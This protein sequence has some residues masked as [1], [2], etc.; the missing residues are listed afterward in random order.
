MAFQ[1]DELLAHVEQHSGE[2]LYYAVSAYGKPLRAKDDELGLC[3]VVYADADGFHPDGFRV[4]PSISVESSP[5]HWHCYW[6]LDRV[7]GQVECARVSMKLPKAHGIDASSGIQTKLLRVPGSVNTKY[8]DTHVVTAYTDYDSGDIKRY[9]LAELDAAYTDV[10]SPMD[11]AVPDVAAPSE[12]PA[13]FDVLDKVPADDRIEWLLAWDKRTADD[14]DKRSEHRWELIRRLMELS[15]LTPEEITS[16]VWDAPVSEHYREQGRGIEH[17]WKF[18]I[19]PALAKQAPTELE[20]LPQSTVDDV[21]FLT[22]DEL[23]AVMSE[24]GFVDHW[25]DLAARALHPNTPLQYLRINAY[26][27]LSACLGNRV[28]ITPPDSG[29]E[30]PY[31]NIWVLNLGPSTTGKSSA[32]RYMKRYISA[33]SKKVGYDIHAGS[34]ATAEGLIKALKAYDKRSAML[35]TDEVSGKFRSWSASTGLAHAREAE[36]EIYD[37]QLPKNLRA[38]DGAGNTDDVY[39]SFVNYMMGVPK[40]VLDP[41]YFDSGYI[42]RSIV[43]LADRQPFDSNRR[44]S[45]QQPDS[46]TAGDFDP[47]P[48]IWAERLMESTRKMVRHSNGA[49]RAIMRFDD[50]AWARFIEF[51][52]Q[53]GEFAESQEEPSIF[54]T[55]ADR[56]VVTMQKL[57]ALTAYERTSGTVQMIDVL[58]VLQD[59]EQW[60][61]WMMELFQQTSDSAFA[62]QQDDVLVW[63]TARGGKAKLSD[64]HNKFSG[65][66]M[67]E[68]LE[69]LDSLQRRGIVSESRNKSGTPVLEA[70]V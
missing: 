39:L 4:P 36:L 63:L 22:A 42:P 26:T 6:V 24:P 61:G 11:Y 66:P 18:D 40:R 45:A 68:R 32:L 35:V 19:L 38:G 16:L 62:R 69:I 20:P 53:L 14:P 51:S 59:A 58:R 15:T 44:R 9:T 30:T 29:S 17:L 27:Y 23:I 31:C 33:F 67:R 3:R 28:A 25:V 56:F 64:Y 48:E 54:H 13:K 43:V 37:G 70:A 46:K 12:W 5:G 55:M 60:W 49:N 47:N 52:V 57:M 50:D 2:D 21:Q 1:R 34:N 65:L 7:Y 41:S 10:V 8:A